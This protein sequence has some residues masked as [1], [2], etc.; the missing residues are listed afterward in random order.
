M[1]IRCREVGGWLFC[2][3]HIRVVSK[4]AQQRNQYIELSEC[5][6]TRNINCV[7]F[8]QVYCCRSAS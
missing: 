1:L 3:L 5:Y 2:L 7:D 8:R 6:H 4:L